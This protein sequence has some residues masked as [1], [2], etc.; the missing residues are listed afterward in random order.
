MRSRQEIESILL[1]ELNIATARYREMSKALN[2]ALW[3][4]IGEIP[5]SDGLLM[6]KQSGLENM[7]VLEEFVRCLFRFNRFV[8]HGTIPDDLLE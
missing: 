8:L 6:V 7:A 4:R 3:A 2:D 5:A 1:T